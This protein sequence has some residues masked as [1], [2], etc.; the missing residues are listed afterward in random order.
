MIIPFFI[1]HAGCPH[2]CVFCD[3]KRITGKKSAVHPA[4]VPATIR[5]FLAAKASDGH[6]EAG[7]QA[8]ERPR[9]VQVA[10][11]GG[12]FTALPPELQQ[13][14][15]REVR[16]FLDAGEV[17]SIRISTR[18][19]RITPGV[20]ALLRKHQVA[21][22][23]LG[24]QSLDNDVLHHSGRGHTSE[25]TVAATRLLREQGFLIG[26]QLMPGLPKDSRTRFRETVI[27]TV[28]LGPDMVR[29]YPVL[30]IRDTPLEKLFHDGVYAPLAREDAVAWCAEAQEQFEAAGI[31]VIRIGLQHT[32]T[33]ARPG[34]VVAGPYHP[35]FGQLVASSRFL[36]L[37]TSVLAD[38]TP[39][40]D[41][42]LRVHPADLSTALGQKKRNIPI[43]LGRT[44]ARKIVV[45][46]DAAVPRGTVTLDMTLDHTCINPL[47]G[48]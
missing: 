46:T 28:E 11:Y 44:K 7:I 24:V 30:V 34:T 39:G 45:R 6:Q 38:I 16:P 43:L 15:L 35:A 1:P 29:I 5:S 2:Q 8:A 19:D 4:S 21:T 40:S 25:H 31:D 27:R 10:F 47:F 33:L 26:Y 18:P 32:E 42:V 17:R 14:Y 37:M 3:Q 41:A 48:I 36:K 12:S 23:E 22:V 13:A 20:L 9:D